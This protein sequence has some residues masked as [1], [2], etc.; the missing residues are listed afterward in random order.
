MVSDNIISG[1]VLVAVAGI[2][3]QPLFF[4]VS[5]EISYSGL[6]I[7]VNHKICFLRIE[8]MFLWIVF[9]YKS[10]N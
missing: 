5:P 7:F 3:E 1:A 6:A 4:Q 9:L 10:K 2:A 8:N